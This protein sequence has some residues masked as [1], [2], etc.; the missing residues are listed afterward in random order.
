MAQFQLIAC[1]INIGGDRD[2]VI[3]RSRH[4]EP[5]TYPEYLVMQ[6]LHGG[7]EHVHHAMSC[8]TVERDQADERTRLTERYGEIVNE[9]FP[10]TGALPLGNDH[11]PTEEE[12]A[13]GEQ[14]AS[15]AR[16]AVRSKRGQRPLPELSGAVNDVPELPA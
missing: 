2:T 14:A 15:K 8:G 6:V 1:G 11:L 9:V 7:N 16:S 4:V 12:V 10:G 5:L 13:A 3:W